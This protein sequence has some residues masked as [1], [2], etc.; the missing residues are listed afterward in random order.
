MSSTLKSIFSGFK[1]KKHKK[2]ASPVQPETSASMEG[3][4]TSPCD[5]QPEQSRPSP[6]P[7]RM[8]GAAPS[9]LSN[10][11]NFQMRDFQYIEVNQTA[12]WDLL[13]EKAAHTA[14]YDSGARFDPPKCDEDTRVE[15]TSEIMG[16]IQDR[17]A[18]TRLLCMTGPAG[19]GKSAIQQ[20]IAER[21]AD[22]GIL[23]ASFFFAAADDTRNDAFPVVPTIAYQLSLASPTLRSLISAVVARDPLIFTRSIEKQMKL[24]IVDPVVRQRANMDIVDMPYVILIDGLDE[25]KKEDRQGEL[26][27]AIGSCL[28]FNNLLPFRVFIASRPEIVIYNALQPSGHLHHA[29]YHIQLDDKY[30]PDSD[31]ERYLRRRFYEIARRC[32]DPRAK[33]PSWPGDPV[34]DTLIRCASGQFIYAATVIRYVQDPRG[35]PV[36][37][38]NTILSWSQD[39]GAGNP[40]ASLHDLYR[41]ILLRARDNY[42]SVDDSREDLMVLIHV[43]LDD[44]LAVHRDYEK[45]LFP[46]NGGLQSL[47]H[48]LRSLIDI[49]AHN[50]VFGP[51][52]VRQEI[53]A[54]YLH[55]Y[56][57]RE[58]LTDIWRSRDLHFDW[59]RATRYITST[60]FAHAER[61][62]ALDDM[63]VPREDRELLS[64]C[65]WIL[66]Y[67]LYNRP[68]DL[69]AVAQ[70]FLNLNLWVWLSFDAAPSSVAYHFCV[71]IPSVE[72][73]LYDR[74]EREIGKRLADAWVAWVN[75]SGIKEHCIF[76]EMYP[77]TGMAPCAQCGLPGGQYTWMQSLALPGSLS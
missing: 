11:S 77:W 24:L 56:T 30:N 8:T 73:Y 27:A 37:R 9:F 65:A 35:S 52:N 68:P 34:L 4:S 66:L 60:C 19:A 76:D 59:A 53:R 47:L 3:S 7:D 32:L 17:G 51:S 64:S 46:E 61:V 22:L 41:Q 12:G 14:L 69:K 39:S 15:V 40:L 62:L 29:A 2:I 33:T 25:C 48:D 13:V 18:P 36:D 54:L 21:C 58:F 1:S 16:W 42:R 72:E 45:I 44:T 10:A 75:S 5:V 71:V 49:H 26:L 67:I 63:E 38:L 23:A 55:H 31:I 74:G 57:F 28:L 50:R 43:A 6:S 20:T 70:Q